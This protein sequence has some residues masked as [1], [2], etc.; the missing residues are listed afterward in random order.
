MEDADP[1]KLIK[2]V[3]KRRR[4]LSFWRGWKRD[5]FFIFIKKWISDLPGSCRDFPPHFSHQ[6]TLS[7]CSSPFIL[8]KEKSFITFLWILAIQWINDL[9]L[10][11]TAVWIYGPQNFTGLLYQKKPVEVIDNLELLLLISLSF[12]LSG[13]VQSSKLC[14]RGNGHGFESQHA[15]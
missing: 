11:P 3:N 2:I 4:E 12:V 7:T 14:S 1:K 5:N 13:T 10:I 8:Y 15:A 9:T 6:C